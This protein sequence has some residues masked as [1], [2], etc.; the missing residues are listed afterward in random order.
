M[1]DLALRK[2]SWSPYIVGAFIGLLSWF[3]FATV[4]QPIGITTAFEYTAALVNRAVQGTDATAN[5]YYLAPD[6]T[7]RINWEWMLVAGVFFGALL[8][9]SASGDR[10]R[11]RV[12]AMWRARFGPGAGKRYA[13]AFAGGWVM[14]FGARLAQ[15]CTSGHGISGALQLALSSWLFLVVLAV[16]AVGTAFLLYGRK[17]AEDV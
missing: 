16:G 6:K 17:E 7:P 8:S 15:G 11:E 5:P 10:T 14:M 1:L 4:D 9:A 13:A 3:S 2:K 12:P